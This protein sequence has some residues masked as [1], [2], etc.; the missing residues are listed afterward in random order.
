MPPMII[1]H[2]F[3]GTYN[4]RINIGIGAGAILCFL[5]LSFFIFFPAQKINLYFSLCNFFFVLTL[6]F[7]SISLNNHGA[8]F[9]FDIARDACI[10]LYLFS[11][12]YCIYKIFNKKPGWI[13][14]SLLAAG[15]IS[16]LLGFF[17][18]N[19]FSDYMSI[20]VLADML[21]ISIRS[22]RNNKSGAWIILGFAAI[23][24][25]YF[26]LSLLSDL[27]IITIP[28]INSYLP[29]CAF[30]SPGKPGYIFRLCFW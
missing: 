29:F 7:Y 4:S 2:D 5:Y 10:I 13:Y 27:A 19:H 9:G 6:I 11:L 25:I 15:I 16:F 24:L 1:L 17:V 3:T 20:L 8:N 28:G 30:D 12:L 26:T 21:R 22:L 14:W 23:D 18:T